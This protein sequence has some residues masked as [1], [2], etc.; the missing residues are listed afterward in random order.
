MCEMLLNFKNLSTSFSMRDKPIQ[1]RADFAK[2][3]N[4]LC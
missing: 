2:T 1:N 4:R 3:I